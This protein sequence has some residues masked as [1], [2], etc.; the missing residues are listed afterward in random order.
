MSGSEGNLRRCNP[1]RASL[2][3][4]L[5]ALQVL[6]SFAYRGAL[7]KRELEPRNLKGPKP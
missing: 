3:P 1:I 2:T 4:E 5:L 7:V 6:G